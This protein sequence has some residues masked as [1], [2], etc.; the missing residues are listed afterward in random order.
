M[1]LIFSYVVWT[2]RTSFNGKDLIYFSVIKMINS[3]KIVLQDNLFWENIKYTLFSLIFMSSRTHFPF[4]VLEWFKSVGQ[5]YKSAKEGK[6]YSY[7]YTA[8]IGLGFLTITLT[9]AMFNIYIPVFLEQLLGDI[10]RQKLIIGVIMVLDNIAAITL[11]PWAGKV[12]DNIWTKFGRRMPFIIISIPI[13]A[14]FFG[15]LPVF[16]DSLVL[17]LVIIG[18][19]NIAMAFY[20]APVIA[21]LPDLVSKDYRSR[22]NAVI[23]LLGGV[24]ALIGL[25][26]MAAIY[27]INPILSFVIVSIIM[28]LCLLALIL[29]IKE[30]KDRPDV[31]TKE[32]VSILK[33]VKQMFTDKDRSLLAILFAILFWFFAFNAIETWFS[34]YATNPGL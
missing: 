13:A 8:I 24:G 17:L 25:F 34:L 22:G 20:R 2:F 31:E 28:L 7:L 3:K 23:N 29:S 18:G 14:V 33:S 27:D 19:F 21:L 32:K 26:V 4:T 15:L 5:N 6:S 12:S 9:W 1:V 16:K 11:Q 10:P 30:S